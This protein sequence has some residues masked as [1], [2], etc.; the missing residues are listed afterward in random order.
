M[1]KSSKVIAPLDTVTDSDEVMKLAQQVTHC[2][3]GGGGI[4]LDTDAEANIL[5]HTPTTCLRLFPPYI[6]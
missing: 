6:Q 1:F 4:K 3:L 2:S 5:P